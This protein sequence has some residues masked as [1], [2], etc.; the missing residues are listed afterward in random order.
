MTALPLPG[1]PP[2]ADH[3]EEPLDLPNPPGVEADRMS[4]D[5]G[6]RRALAVARSRLTYWQTVVER[7]TGETID[8]R[9]DDQP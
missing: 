1:L 9:P 8:S 6:T 5:W 4:G 7:L 2:N 3:Y